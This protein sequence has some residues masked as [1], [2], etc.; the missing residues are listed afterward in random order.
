MSSSHI[1]GEKS[2]E[3][4]RTVLDVPHDTYMKTCVALGFLDDENE[5]DLVMTDSA[6]YDMPSKMRA[7]MVICWYLMRLDILWV[8]LISIGGQWTG[9]LEHSRARVDKSIN[10]DDNGNS[11]FNNGQRSVL[12]TLM[13]DNDDETS[14]SRVFSSPQLVV[15]VR[16]T[17]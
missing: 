14:H 10:G 3:D 12:D 8:Y 17:F 7:T 2:F 6:L 13:D 11:K 15:L 1:A 5:W 9:D 4:V 16:P